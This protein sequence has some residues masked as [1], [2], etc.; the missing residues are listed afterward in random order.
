M[1]IRETGCHVSQ[2]AVNYLTVNS[3][4]NQANQRLNIAA[5]MNLLSNTIGVI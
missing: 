1:A 4:M 2:R 5:G 3:N